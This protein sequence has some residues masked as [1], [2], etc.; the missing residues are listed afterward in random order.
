MVARDQINAIRVVNVT[1]NGADAGFG[2]LGARLKQL[3]PRGFV[4]IDT[5]FSGLG[6][7]PDLKHEN[8]QTRYTA[9][10]TLA[11]SCG[12]LSVGISVFD[13]INQDVDM[14]APT[15]HSQ[16][17]TDTDLPKN[18]S[19]TPYS[20]S[21]YDFLMCCKT[22]FS[23]ISD[24]GEFLVAHGFDFNRLFSVGIPYERA[25]S[26]KPAE[27]AEKNALP[28]KWGKLPKGLLWRIGHSNVPIVIHNGLFDLVF[29]FASF[30][31]ALPETLNEFISAFR[32]CV[33]SGFW[34]TKVIAS[35]TKQRSTF[36]AYLFAQSVLAE[37]ICVETSTGLPGVENADPSD[38]QRYPDTDVLCALYAFRGFCPRGIGCPFVH[39]PFRIIEEERNGTC[40]KDSKEAYKRHKV[41]SKAL[42]KQRAELQSEISK[43]NKKQ[44]KRLVETAHPNGLN[45]GNESCDRIETT[46]RSRLSGEGS[47]PA[48]IV[49]KA[50]TAGWDAFCTGYIFAA[51]RESLDSKTLGKYMNRVALPYKQSSLLLAESQFANLD[52]TAEVQQAKE[53]GA[54]DQ[55]V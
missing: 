8:M 33:P 39:D 25:S 28:W 52:S 43:L 1:R 36:L 51:F 10:R 27:T 18:H 26:E 30:Q 55:D 35:N 19:S 38:I 6:S 24:S 17:G 5:E 2:S 4:A 48:C 53:D 47:K 23:M 13:Q 29:L 54:D 14:L 41:Q 21:T 3:S 44:K 42:K 7:D 34:D 20:V 22:P 40:P 45:R 12:I 31:G 32:Q 15:N 50:H 11:H 9:L 49:G 37:A 46:V 16:V